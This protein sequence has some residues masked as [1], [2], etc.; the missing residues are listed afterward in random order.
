MHNL[1]LYLNRCVSHY[2]G[3]N[4]IYVFDGYT[5]A[6]PKSQKKVRFVTELAWQSH[7]VTNMFIR[8]DKAPAAF[9]PD[10]TIINACKVVDKD[11]K[12]HG[13]NSE[14]FIAFNIEKKVAVIGKS[15]TYIFIKTI[16]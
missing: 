4:E 11:W 2:N 3:L 8:P 15:S 14:V 1:I 9:T 16:N 10:F 13:L 5:G 7:F 12:K 6:N